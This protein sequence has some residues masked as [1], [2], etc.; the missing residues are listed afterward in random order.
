MAEVS[1][2]V[3]LGQG[4]G[5]PRSGVGVSVMASAVHRLD[6]DGDQRPVQVR[7]DLD[8]HTGVA[9]LLENRPGIA[10]QSQVGQ[11]VPST[12]TVPAPDAITPLSL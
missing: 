2:G 4:L 5:Q 9:G 3:D 1:D 6:T 10:R 7:P 8:V 12:S 11:I